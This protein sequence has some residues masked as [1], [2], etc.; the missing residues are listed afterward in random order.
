MVNKKKLTGFII[1]GFAVAHAATAFTL[2]QTLVGD[3]AALTALTIAMI[4]TVAKINGADWSVSKAFSYLGVFAGGYFGSRG[5]VFLIKWIPGIGNLANATVSFA[6]TEAMG[7][8]TYLIIQK[9]KDPENLSKKDAAAIWKEA[10]VMREEEKG[11]M[12]K[13]YESMNPE[14]KN[15]FDNIMNQLQNKDLPKETIDYL[16]SRLEA[17]SS[18]YVSGDEP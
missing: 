16:S 4:V 3:E 13:L 9:S 10:K 1:H 14:E 15:E 18:K 5:A 11:K 7:W 12:K 6:L 8:A 17:I 2:A